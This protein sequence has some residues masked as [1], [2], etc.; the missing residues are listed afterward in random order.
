MGN[1]N[2]PPCITRSWPRLPHWCR[3]AQ[4]LL[5]QSHFRLSLPLPTV[6][7]SWRGLSKGGRQYR[8]SLPRG[9][10]E[11]PGE[12]EWKQIQAKLEVAVGR[13]ETPTMAA[14]PASGVALGGSRSLRKVSAF[15]SLSF[16]CFQFVK[17]KASRSLYVVLDCNRGAVSISSKSTIEDCLVLRLDITVMHHTRT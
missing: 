6:Y 16:F 2:H 17:K 5:P 9:S 12:V 3:A 1:V 4:P 13:S 10:F 15:A 7:L 11:L 14:Q 8:W